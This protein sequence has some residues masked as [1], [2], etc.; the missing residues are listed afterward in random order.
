MRTGRE[1]VPKWHKTHSI[2]ADAMWAVPNQDELHRGIQKLEAV[3][4]DIMFSSINFPNRIF[5][6]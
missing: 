6:S 5:K 3:G 2:S 1:H 4:L